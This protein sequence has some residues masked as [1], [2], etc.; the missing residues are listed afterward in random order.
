MKVTLTKDIFI[1]NTGTV[2]VGF[3]KPKIDGEECRSYLGIW[4][5]DCK[6]ILLN[7]KDSYQ[8]RIHVDEYLANIV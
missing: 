6:P 7:G 2:N 1:Y 8:L 4:V 3:N 5:A